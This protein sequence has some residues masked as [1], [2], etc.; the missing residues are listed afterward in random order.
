MRAF[1]FGA[2]LRRLMPPGAGRG[3]CVS[4]GGFGREAGRKRDGQT[5]QSFSRCH[6][7]IMAAVGLSVCRSVTLLRRDSVEV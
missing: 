5:F 3:R 7:A 1:G 2:Q 6:L 4:A